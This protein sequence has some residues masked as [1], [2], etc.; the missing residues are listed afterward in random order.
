MKI[1]ARCI[2]WYTV[3]PNFVISDLEGEEW[4]KFLGVENK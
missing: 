4:K 1:A 3:T 2:Y